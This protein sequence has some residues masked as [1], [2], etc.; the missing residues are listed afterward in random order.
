MAKKKYTFP[1]LDCPNC[2]YHQFVGD[3]VVRTR[4][5]KGFPKKR[6]PKRFKRSD[7]MYKPPKWCPRRISPPVCR[8]YGFADQ[9]SEMMNFLANRESLGREQDAYISVSESRYKLRREVPLGMTAKR[10]YEDIRSDYL[11]SALCDV[12]VEYGEVIEI[13][14]GLKPYYFYYVNWGYVIPL[15]RF[16]LSRVQPSGPAPSTEGGKEP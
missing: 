11:N 16:S 15:L 4:Y 7:P 1:G 14:D 12:D 6:K 2:P 10:F 3:S 13:D 8:I 5:C 9:E